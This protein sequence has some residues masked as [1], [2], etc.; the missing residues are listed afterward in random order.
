MTRAVHAAPDPGQ[1]QEVAAGWAHR[2]RLGP[3]RRL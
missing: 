1:E 3:A 2:L